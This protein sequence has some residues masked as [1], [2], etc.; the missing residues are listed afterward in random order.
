[1]TSAFNSWTGLTPAINGYKPGGTTLSQK[2]GVYSS[3]AG[4]GAD[5]TI[6][7][8]FGWPLS[9]AFAT[10][11]ADAL[12]VLALGT[13]DCGAVPAGRATAPPPA[14]GTA[15]GP[16]HFVTDIVTAQDSLHRSGVSL[17]TEDDSLTSVV[18]RQG[19]SGN[20]TLDLRVSRG[21][22][23][24]LGPG[25][26]APFG[27]APLQGHAGF[28]LVNQESTVVNLMVT[29][30]HPPMQ[31]PVSLGPYGSVALPP[32][33][34]PAAPSFNL[35][36]ANLSTTTRADLGVEELGYGFPLVLPA[37]PP[38]AFTARLRR[39]QAS[40]FVRFETTGHDANLGNTVSLALHGGA[41]PVGVTPMPIP[42]DAATVRLHS[43]RP[44][45]S[46][47]D[48]RI[49]F[50]LGRG[51][52]VEVTLFDVQ[53]R[54]VRRLSPPRLGPGSSDVV[55]D[56]AD[57]SGGQAPPGVYLVRLTLDGR[58]AA[59]GKVLRIR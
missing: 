48:V 42:A 52:N 55:W 24:A 21:T 8:L 59:D 39:G 13:N 35:T 34:G 5:N 23:V 19:G 54:L 1:V 25:A 36:I 50:D 9:T 4:A 51:G 6:G 15:G 49:A 43:P 33:S 14:A 18:Q 46:A 26:S 20:A 44:Q 7:A 31:Q 53:G 11:R 16:L 37:S 29:L 57:Q 38:G 12:A 45:P 27:I 47:G 17:D 10:R 58:H 40:E 41:G 3:A 56:G 28:L 22:E 30:S 32:Y 2:T